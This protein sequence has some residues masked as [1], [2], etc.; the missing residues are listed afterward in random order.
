MLEAVT[1]KNRQGGTE[2]LGGKRGGRGR[3]GVSRAE[4]LRSGG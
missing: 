4:K 2:R 3:R 1:V